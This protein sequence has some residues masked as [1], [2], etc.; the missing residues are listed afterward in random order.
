MYS[1]L[2][3]LAAAIFAIT[4]SMTSHRVDALVLPA[5]AVIPRHG[6]ADSQFP[7]TLSENMSGYSGPGGSASGGSI[8][9]SGGNSLVE[10]LSHNAGN[11][12]EANSATG[13]GSP[14]K[15]AKLDRLD[16]DA[17]EPSRHSPLSSTGATSISAYSGPGGH[18]DGGSVHDVGHD[19]IPVLSQN[20]GSAGD[21]DSLVGVLL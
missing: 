15:S 16:C 19:W 5:P 13:V 20:A 18:A 8:T 12:G 3:L 9:D 4:V 11:G 14:L 6:K 17:C 1:Y 21:A 2:R 7:P 10:V